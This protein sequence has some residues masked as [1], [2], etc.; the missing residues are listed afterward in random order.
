MSAVPRFDVETCRASAEL[1]LED[2]F[3]DTLDVFVFSWMLRSNSHEQ[4][5]A[6]QD[7]ICCLCACR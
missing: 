5:A 6:S 3:G 7:E 1:N 2:A 4:C